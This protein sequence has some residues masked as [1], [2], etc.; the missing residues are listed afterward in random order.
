VQARRRLQRDLLLQHLRHMRQA[1]RTRRPAWR[2]AGAAG[3]PPWAPTLI[4]PRAASTW[5]P[6]SSAITLRVHSL[7]F[8]LMFSFQS[9]MPGPHL[10]RPTQ[11]A[12]R[13]MAR[14]RTVISIRQPL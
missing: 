9:R 4:W 7:L 5:P 8:L 14:S 3:R 10:D 6:L 1:R 12:G 2:P 13:L 11:G